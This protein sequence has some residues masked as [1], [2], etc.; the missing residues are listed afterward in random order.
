MAKSERQRQAKLTRKRQ[1]KA[2]RTRGGGGK[3][4]R[5]VLNPMVLSEA[6]THPIRD[7][8]VNSDW[9]ESGEATIVFAREVKAAR[10]ALTLG[11]Y[12]VDLW[13]RGVRDAWAEVDVPVQEYERERL[14]K[15]YGEAATEE[16][17][18]EVATAIVYR[19]VEYASSLGLASAPEFGAARLVLPAPDRADTAVEIPLGREG[20]PVIRLREDDDE[21]KVVAAL[22]AKLGTGNYEIHTEAEEAEA[23]ADEP[24]LS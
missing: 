11:I 6:R 18:P 2:V 10:S 9:R 22:D 17:A 5:R 16:I 13:G 23:E 19:A 4:T 7:V 3:A 14:S 8:R 24:E 12:V 21:A 15:V 1:K 20:R